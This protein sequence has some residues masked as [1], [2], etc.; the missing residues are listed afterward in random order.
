M[1]TSLGILETKGFAAAIT[2][3]DKIL[4]DHSVDLIMVEKTGGGIISLFFKGE[5]EKLKTAFEKGIR[6]ARSVGEIMALHIFAKL[7]TQIEKLLFESNVATELQNEKRETVQVKSTIRRD[8]TNIEKGK[9]EKRIK[10]AKEP[11]HKTKK[12]KSSKLI[13]TTSTIQRLRREALS[14]TKISQTKDT[15][16]RVREEKEQSAINMNVVENLSVHELR[17]LARNVNDFPIQGREISKANRK[18]L[19]I[20]FKEL[21]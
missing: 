5:T 10:E 14:S 4:E 19:V 11:N 9:V 8:D 1:Q 7:N 12:I 3:A 6:E 20:Y 18:E 15:N 2:A 21:S 13:G 16:S 17:K